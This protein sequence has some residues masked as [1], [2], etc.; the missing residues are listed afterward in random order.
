ML[1]MGPALT[2]LL[3]IAGAPVGSTIV[4]A[5]LSAGGPGDELASLLSRCNGFYAFESALHVR[6]AGPTGGE[7]SVQEWNSE[8]LWRSAYGAMSEGHLFFAEDAFGGQFSIK[9]EQVF[10]FDPE[11]GDAVAL[12]SSLEDWAD[13]VLFDYEVL[14]GFPVAHDW[15]QIHGALPAGARLV[16][17]QPF[18]L[19]GEYAVEN[20]HALDAAESMLYRAEIAVQIRDLPEG[21]SV[22]FKVVE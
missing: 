17:K 16:P 22:T 20:L 12:S 21:A 3:S 14:T 10:T 5:P 13:Q 18:V 4:D 2:K 15:Q 11:T 8:E 6:A 9:D 19:G 7:P 1:S